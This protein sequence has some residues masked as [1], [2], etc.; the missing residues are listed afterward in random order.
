MTRMK[1]SPPNGYKKI[2]DWEGKRIKNIREFSSFSQ[3]IPANSNGTVI[4]ATGGVGL[5]IQFD[6]CHCCGIQA[7]F[8]SVHDSD[9]VLIEEQNQ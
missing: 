1:L 4:R 8:T 7:T 3:K 6:K 2:I 5:A 9:I